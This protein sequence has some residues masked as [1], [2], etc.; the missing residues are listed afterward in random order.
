MGAAQRRAPQPGGPQPLY[1]EGSLSGSS[2]W[3]ALNQ[4]APLCTPPPTPWGGS[5][6]LAVH[7]ARA[8]SLLTHAVPHT[9]WWALVGFA[10][11]GHFAS[12]GGGARGQTR[13][14]NRLGLAPTR[15]LCQLRLAP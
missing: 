4:Q 9:A 1:L 8:W 11:F 14:Q 2:I 5:L 10:F 6:T 7:G 13:G 15:R 3:G 12:G